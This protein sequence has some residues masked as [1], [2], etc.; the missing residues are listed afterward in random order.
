MPQV[1]LAAERFLV[2]ESPPF[3]V[4]AAEEERLSRAI[5]TGLRSAGCEVVGGAV[6][7]E[8]CTTA[9]CWKKV[10]ASNEATDILVV[11]GSYQGLGWQMSFE[12]RNGVTGGKVG[13]EKENCDACPFDAMVEKARTTAKHIAESD[14]GESE[15]AAQPAASPP[16]LPSPPVPAQPEPEANPLTTPP[17]E[18]ASEGHP[19][20]PIF[21]MAGGGAVLASG[22]VL[23]AIDGRDTDCTQGSCLRRYKTMTPGLILGGVGLAAIAVG[24]WQYVTWQPAGTAVS[25]QVG[26][27]SLTLA[28]GF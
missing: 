24:I 5:Q 13:S 2:V 20:W 18:S 14:R 25:V 12:H 10:A 21:L 16:A 1:A 11:T 3:A 8:T 22:I 28:G 7:Q 26:P 27:G 23:M 9:A 15:S 19:L 6:R 17:Q 4:R